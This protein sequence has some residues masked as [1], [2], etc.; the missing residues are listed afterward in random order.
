MGNDGILCLAGVSPHGQEE[1]L[2]IGTINRTMVL[3]NSVIFG[4][5]N[6]NRRHYEMAERALCKADRGWLSK[7][8]TR[9]EPLSRW[10]EALKRKP[11]DIKVILQLAAA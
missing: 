1:T 8:I 2:D 9:R 4:S 11:D 7:L 3:E 10:Q 6:A 5:V